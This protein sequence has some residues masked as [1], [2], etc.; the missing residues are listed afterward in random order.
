MSLPIGTDNVILKIVQAVTVA[1]VLGGGTML[2]TGAQDNA[3]QDDK[4]ARQ[5]AV[6]AGV[7]Y[8]LDAIAAELNDTNKQL[9]RIVGRMEAAND[10]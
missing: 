2:V 4:L 9:A 1:G 8:K 7:M 6:T 10:Q 5:E 3:V